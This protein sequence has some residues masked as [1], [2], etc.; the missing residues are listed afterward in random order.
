[1]QWAWPSSL[2]RWPVIP[3]SPSELASCHLSRPMWRKERS[4]TLRLNQ[5]SFCAYLKQDLALKQSRRIQGHGVFMLNEVYRRFTEKWREDTHDQNPADISSL[6]ILVPAASF[7]IPATYLSSGKSHNL[8]ISSV[9]ICASPLEPDLYIWLKK[10]SL[11]LTNTRINYSLITS[12][13]GSFILG[14]LQ[15]WYSGL[16]KSIYGLGLSL[17]LIMKPVPLPTSLKRSANLSE[18][19]KLL[20]NELQSSDALGVPTKCKCKTILYGYFPTQTTQI[21]YRRKKSLCKWT[22][23][24]IS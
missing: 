18:A 10:I 21:F 12:L 3:D 17:L 19:N 6:D 15:P 2:R 13:A 1:M 16:R 14:C 22:H 20:Y 5:S 4:R 24:Q 11:V 9:I 7:S 23:G 8:W